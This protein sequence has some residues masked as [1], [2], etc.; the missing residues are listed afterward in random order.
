MESSL[1]TRCRHHVAR[2]LQKLIFGGLALTLGLVTSCKDEAAA[3]TSQTSEAKTAQTQV[4]EPDTALLPSDVGTEAPEPTPVPVEVALEPQLRLN[5]ESRSDLAKRLVTPV[6]TLSGEMYGSQDLVGITRAS[7]GEGVLIQPIFRGKKGLQVGIPIR[8]ELGHLTTTQP[9]RYRDRDFDVEAHFTEDSPE[10]L[11]GMVKITHSVDGPTRTLVTL[12]VDAKPVEGQLQPALDTQKNPPFYEH[13][14]PTGYFR[15][16]IGP[17]TFKGYVN[18]RNIGK[19]AAPLISIPV[20]PYDRLEFFFISPKPNHEFKEPVKFDLSNANQPEGAAAVLMSKIVQLRPVV[21]PLDATTRN[22]SVAR[23]ATLLEGSAE[24]TLIKQGTR[25]RV[26]LELENLRMPD[27]IKGPLEG[28]L[29]ER[30]DIEANLGDGSATPAVDGAP[31]WWTGEG[32][33]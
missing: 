22:L 14:T 18:V 19:K 11:K 25:W 21:E 1:S 28:A 9:V 20:T 24:V 7:C 16:Q 32:Y 23:E 6:G 17:K 4:P 30:I 26:T 29:F 31:D 5:T 8:L 12:D 2:Q 10:R 27:G 15:A 3:P 13:C 33:D